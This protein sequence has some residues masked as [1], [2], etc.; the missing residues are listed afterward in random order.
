VLSSQSEPGNDGPITAHVTTIEIPE[1]LSAATYHTQQSAPT[2]FVV[3]VDPEMVREAVDPGSQQGN[4]Q[5]RGAGV[6]VVGLILFL[7][8]L[9][10]RLF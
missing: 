2:G 10:L 3:V 8:R 4:L 7:D 6:F 5:F 9:H 1:E